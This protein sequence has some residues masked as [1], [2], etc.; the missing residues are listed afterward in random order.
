MDEANAATIASALNSDEGYP[1]PSNSDRSASLDCTAQI[2]SAV[3]LP[4]ERV[5]IHHIEFDFEH[6]LNPNRQ[7]LVFY[8]KPHG[9][10]GEW[11]RREDSIL[12][13][14]DVELGATSLM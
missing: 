5:R 6:N 12:L 11:L 1:T 13:L 14:G 7:S 8:S 9:P 2:P 4:P 10:Y 3:S